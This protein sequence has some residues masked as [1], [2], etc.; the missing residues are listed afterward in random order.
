MS[1]Y[2]MKLPSRDETLS[3]EAQPAKRIGF[4]LVPGFALMAY[5]SAIEPFRA[6]NHFSGRTLYSWKHIS[7][8]GRPVPASNGVHILPEHK[9]GDQ[10]TLDMVF[11]CAG[12]N[13]A[14]F[15][16]PATLQWLRG[17][18]RKGT[19]IGGIS[20]GPFIIA[21]AGL[22]SG[23][24]CTIHWEH[25]PAFLEEFPDLDLTRAL[26]E[27]DRDRLTCSGGIAPLDMMHALIEAEHGHALASAV[28][29]W[30]LHAK[31]R[32]GE[33]PQRM[34]LRERFSVSHD[35]LLKVLEHMEANLE[36]PVSRQDLARVAGLSVRQMERLFRIYLRRTLGAH[37]LDLRLR[38]ARQLLKESSLPVLEVAVACGFVSASHFSRVYYRRF[39]RT[40]RSER[41]PRPR[42]PLAEGLVGRSPD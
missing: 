26:F 40:P 37:Y 28:S 24:H 20:G 41:L 30:F 13:P 32:E 6:A 42:T 25:I 16:D 1:I 33:N 3:T 12:G 4:L 2:D 31:I 5:S 23:Y 27:I 21:R 10:I 8:N 22:L 11:V 14:E 15:N 34:A 38:R 36:E 7:P 39:S 9:V 19:K 17:L 35:R 18:A 29:E